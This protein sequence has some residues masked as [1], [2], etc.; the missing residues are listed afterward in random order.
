M[1]DGDADG[2]GILAG[3]ASSLLVENLSEYSSIHQFT[4]PTP[5]GFPID[6]DS[7]KLPL[8]IRS[9]LELGQGEPTAETDPSVVLD[10]RAPDDRPQLVD[11]ARG[12]GGSLC[13]TG[14]TAAGLL[15]GL[16]PGKELSESRFNPFSPIASLPD[17]PATDATHLVEVCPD[18]ALPILSEICKSESVLPFSSQSP[19]AGSSR[20]RPTVVGDLLVVLDRLDSEGNQLAN[21]AWMY[22]YK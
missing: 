18:P 10:G 15:S 20:G 6:L 9:Y 19:I 22:K 1:V 14:I 16:F 2:G 13:A 8:M 21:T 5:V 7:R 12:N 17:F 4:I 11:R 3:D